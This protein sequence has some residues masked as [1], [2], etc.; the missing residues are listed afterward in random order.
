MSEKVL[1]IFKIRMSFAEQFKSNKSDASITFL[2]R[3]KIH[4][5]MT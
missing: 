3:T 1:M 2:H 4:V 5:I